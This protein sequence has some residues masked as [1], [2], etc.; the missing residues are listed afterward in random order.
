MKGEKMKY[1]TNSLP[2]ASYLGTL[3][4]VSFVGTDK[5]NPQKIIF[6][7]EPGDLA[8]EEADKFF[9]GQVEKVIQPVD[10]F[11]NYRSMKDLVFEARR[12]Y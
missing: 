6:E 11:K 12:N 9:A 7:F 1:K 5:E 8:S 3:D 2:L 4:E 10:I